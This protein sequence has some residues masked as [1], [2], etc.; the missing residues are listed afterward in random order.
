[1]SKEKSYKA[2][3]SKERDAVL[4]P[5]PKAAASYEAPQKKHKR[6][7]MRVENERAIVETRA[8]EYLPKHRPLSEIENV[9][10]LRTTR[11]STRLLYE[12]K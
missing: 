3:K 6:F 5:T 4:D 11:Q 1:M 10:S 7:L 12:N 2:E 9:S 8:Y